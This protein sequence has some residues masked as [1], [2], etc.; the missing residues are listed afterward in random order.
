MGIGAAAIGTGLL[1][2]IS[3]FS[4]P[5]AGPLCTGDG[6]VTRQHGAAGHRSQCSHPGLLVQTLFL[7]LCIILTG[8]CSQYAGEEAA[9]K[10][11]TQGRCPHCSLPPVP[12]GT[13]FVARLAEMQTFAWGK[14]GSQP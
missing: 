2:H 9:W 4:C 12:Q 6:K 1:M 5:R 3:S 8:L 13:A 14:S 7:L 10:G 11:W